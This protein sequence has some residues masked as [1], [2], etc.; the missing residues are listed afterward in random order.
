MSEYLDEKSQ[1]HSANAPTRSAAM[2]FI[3]KTDPLISVHT[4]THHMQGSVI[5]WK[6]STVRHIDLASL[7]WH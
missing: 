4:P 7:Y 2:V 6:S 5:I 1:Y 3:I